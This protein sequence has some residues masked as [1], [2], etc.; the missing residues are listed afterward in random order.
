MKREACVREVKRCIVAME[1]LNEAA[2]AAITLINVIFPPGVD[3]DNTARCDVPQGRQV[4][5]ES[6]NL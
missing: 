6:V 5:E 3:S 2:R 4:A 1:G